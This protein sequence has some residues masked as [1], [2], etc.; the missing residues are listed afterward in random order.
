[1]GDKRLQ[2]TASRTKQNRVTKKHNTDTKTQMW[3]NLSLLLFSG[4]LADWIKKKKKK[5]KKKKSSKK[6][7]NLFYGFSFF[8]LRVLRGRFTGVISTALT[9]VPLFY[10]FLLLLYCWNENAGLRSTATATIGSIKARTEK[11]CKERDLT[12]VCARSFLLLLACSCF[13]L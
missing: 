11:S 12:C 10:L 8:F 1:M 2:Y 9:V 4:L 6:K 13:S 5:G 7:K 3:V